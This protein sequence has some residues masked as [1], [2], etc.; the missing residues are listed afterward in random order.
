MGTRGSGG[1]LM[2]PMR[3][4]RCVQPM[5]VSGWP[6]HDWQKVS[7]Y[8]EAHNDVYTIFSM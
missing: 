8:V 6:I 2:S 1:S 4:R 7:A 3:D 5:H